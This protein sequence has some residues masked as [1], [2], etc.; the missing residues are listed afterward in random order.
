MTNMKAK[1]SIFSLVFVLILAA[2]GGN[3]G[4]DENSIKVGV[5]YSLS[6]DMAISETPQYNAVLL[7]IEEIN[8]AGGINGK[9]II[10]I[11]EDYN[12]DPSEAA[13]KANKLIKEDEVA[14]IIGTH[15]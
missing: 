11:E 13:T 15:N 1:L 9:E 2:C 7:A 8:E 14:A 10:P 3:D 5:L 12:S 6:G 4:E